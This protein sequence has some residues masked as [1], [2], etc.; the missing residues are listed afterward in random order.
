MACNQCAIVR[1]A[2][3]V[4]LTIATPVKSESLPHQERYAY[5]FPVKLLMEPTQIEISQ[6]STP[7]DPLSLPL[8]RPAP[9]PEIPSA[10]EPLPAPNDLLQPSPSSP[11]PDSS[12]LSPESLEES[13]VVKQFIVL[14]STVFSDEELAQALNAFR[15][16]PLTFEEL[17]QARDAI[18]ALY[19]NQGYITSGAFIP[20]G[21]IIEDS[22]V[23]IQVLE[24]R[25]SD[26]EIEG[27]QRLRPDYVRS[28]L[29]VAS[30]PP[31]NIQRLLDALQI[32]QLNPIIETISA[33]L[34]ATPKPGE[35][36][37]IVRLK[38]AK[39]FTLDVQL[40]NSA[41]PLIGT[42]QQ[43]VRAREGNLSGRG[44]A[45]TVSYQ[46][47][48]ESNTFE[49]EY[50]LPINPHNG[51]FDLR[52]SY[53]ENQIIEPPLSLTSPQSEAHTWEIGVRQPI[54]ESP[55][56]TVTLGLHLE[57]RSSQSFI[58]PFGAPNRIPFGFPGSGAT[59]QGLTR[60]TALQFSQ[61]W[62]HRTPNQLLFLDSR[63][64]LGIDWLGA[65]GNPE[66]G[67]PDIDFFAWQGQALW[68]QRL[69][70]NWLLLARAAGQLAD[71]P[72]VASEQFGLG[73]TNNVRGYRK[74]Q[75]QADN[76]ILVS[77]ELQT[78]I[79]RW[80][81][82][83]TTVSIAPFIDYGLAWNHDN[84]S[85][86]E[87]NLASVGTGLIF[88]IS[89]RFNA[90]LD[91]AIPLIEIAGNGNSLQESGFSFVIDLGLF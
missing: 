11:L 88:Q 21:Q 6:V 26:I 79:L 17:L 62:Q 25:L 14:G 41:S 42:F 57:Q 32:L 80:P 33:E 43:R 60:V 81:E 74:D 35:N 20:A 24:G 82:Q 59:E 61:E 38:E 87:R 48:G 45:L 55:E 54:L 89:D 86:P 34:V 28:R 72:L 90:R 40:N 47:A 85:L 8:D 31:L 63:F 64:R 4:L 78:P 15:E 12:P 22:I 68:L 83:E 39:T 30:G 46:H 5:T 27:S 36:A 91:Y 53:T 29:A 71:R 69:D 44:D 9:L 10:P 2:A 13:T 19:V 58:Q 65:T 23:T 37:L 66:P 51:S 1:I 16:R 77:L 75:I 70:P 73:G 84:Q 49:A 50:Q 18:T 3:L 76:G 67:E 56:N 52:Y 7:S